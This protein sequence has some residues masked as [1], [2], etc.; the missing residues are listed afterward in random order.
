MT[1]YTKER[2]A[3]GGS[4]P[5]GGEGSAAFGF[6]E[7][8]RSRTV[9]PLGQL[10]DTIF[11]WWRG[12]VGGRGRV[13]GVASLS[14]CYP[15]AVPA[16]AAYRAFRDERAATSFLEQAR[17][18]DGPVCPRC[19]A[20]ARSRLPDAAGRRWCGR[21]RR[22]YSVR[23]ETILARGHA[24]LRAWA[25]GAVLTANGPFTVRP[26]ALGR[27]GGVSAGAARAVADG[28]RSVCGSRVSPHDRPEQLAA[29]ITSAQGDRRRTSAG[30]SVGRPELSWLAGLSH[31]RPAVPDGVDRWLT[32]PI[33][34]EQLAVGLPPHPRPGITES[35]VLVL[36]VLRSYLNGAGSAVVAGAAGM[37]RRNA[38]RVLR[39]LEA[40]GYVS[41]STTEVPW[42]HG[43]RRLLGWRLVHGGLGDD[44]RPYLPVM[45]WRRRS[46]CPETLPPQFR[47]LFWSG[48]DPAD[49]RLPR[50]A[51]LVANRLLNGRLLD[52]DA[53]R[54][55]LRC[56]PLDALVAQTGIP[57]CP[58]SVELAV[59]EMVDHKSIE[60]HL[61]PSIGVG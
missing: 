61:E 12:R 52:F 60:S 34:P 39:C 6:A 28:I 35:E 44:L 31:I 26:G 46:R 32:P 58:K 30:E 55:A 25:V 41:S 18:P 19:G 15:N 5:L 50:D 59:A 29:R 3:L 38:Q 9:S 7:P 45:R 16:E 17:W 8:H 23:T 48:P 11:G 54:W 57:G 10:G 20:G 56:L 33:P 47:Y 24:P 53:R 22:R 43:T 40:D 36:T 13:V 21:C 37:T 51:L 14:L 49:I 1:S 27:M 42:K 4:G 2:S